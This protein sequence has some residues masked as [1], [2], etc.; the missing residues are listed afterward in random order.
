M[1]YFTPYTSMYPFMGAMQPAKTGIISSLLGKTG[2]TVGTVFT[3]IQKTLNFIN[4]TIPVVKQVSPMVKN[5][6][7]MFKVMNEFKKVNTPLKDSTNETNET[8]KTNTQLP[9]NEKKETIVY[10]QSD[11]LPTF[12]V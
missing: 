7:T 8:N 9:I 3:N 12:F 10:K 6:K 4:Q 1:N 11:N 2:L 5:A